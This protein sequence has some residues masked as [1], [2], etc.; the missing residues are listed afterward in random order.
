MTSAIT[1]VASGG[2]QLTAWARRALL[3][4]LRGH[5][6]SGRVGSLSP[7][8][9]VE[10]TFSCHRQGRL[11]LTMKL[12]GQNPPQR[13]WQRPGSLHQTR[14]VPRVT[15]HLPSCCFLLA[16]PPSSVSLSSLIN[17]FCSRLPQ[18]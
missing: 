2:Q 4:A 11:R 7:S 8:Y 6:P 10:G 5:C 15:P 9:G 16:L 12:R 14:D 18:A 13:T 3:C 1:S 17:L